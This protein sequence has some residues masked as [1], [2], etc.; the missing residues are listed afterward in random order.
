M[1]RSR[2]ALAITIV[3]SALA[4]ASRPPSTPAGSP[5]SALAGTWRGSAD[6][7]VKWTTARTLTV[8]LTIDTL[9]RVRGHVGD[10]ELLNGILRP[11]AG[12]MARA[13]GRKPELIVEGDLKGPVIASE[14]VR[15]GQVTIPLDQHDGHL[16]GSLATSG[17][18]NGIP[19]QMVLTAAG[20]VLQRK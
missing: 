15:R 2:R 3:A 9:Q 18:D 12:F 4:A 20:L 16:V 8:E 6:V 7:G 17:S 5:L 19:E 10:A 13:I 14:E 1:R 11:N